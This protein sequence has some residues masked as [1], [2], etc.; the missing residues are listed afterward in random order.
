MKKDINKE[1]GVEVIEDAN[2]VKSDHLPIYPMI[3]SKR[4]GNT[5][6][7]ETFLRKKHRGKWYLW[8]FSRNAYVPEGRMDFSSAVSSFNR[9]I[10]MVMLYGKVDPKMKGFGG[11]P[12]FKLDSNQ[13]DEKLRMRPLDYVKPEKKK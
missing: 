8:P 7:M 6:S 11:E 13:M 12:Y 2:I 5:L 1:N 10:Y 3:Q 9:D 4:N